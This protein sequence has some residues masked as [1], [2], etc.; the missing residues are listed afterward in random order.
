MS[1]VK[2]S[3][4]ARLHCLIGERFAAI[5]RTANLLWVGLGNEL[6][7]TTIYP[8]RHAKRTPFPRVIP[9][10]SLHVQCAWRLTCADEILCA[11][12]DFYTVKDESIEWDVFSNNHFDEKRDILAQRLQCETIRVRHITADDFGGLRI[13]LDQNMALEIFP[14][15]SRKEEQWRFFENAKN[16]DEGNPHFI[17]FDTD[18]EE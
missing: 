1:D 4:E 7:Q 5:G 2:N 3:I 11:N 6:V 17:V 14:N 13:C 8:R 10:Y 18:G 16:I 15:N 12:G 9:Q